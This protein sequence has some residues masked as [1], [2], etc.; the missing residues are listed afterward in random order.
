MTATASSF[1]N[2]LLSKARETAK[3]N[4]SLREFVALPEVAAGFD[5]EFVNLAVDQRER[6]VIRLAIYLAQ[7]ALPVW[8]ESHPSLT[9]PVEAVAQAEKWTESPCSESAEMASSTQPA[10]VHDSLSVW[11]QEPKKAAWAGRT[12]AWVA[13]APKHGWQAVA[14]IMGS[15]EA[16]GTDEALSLAVRFHSAENQT[17]QSGPRD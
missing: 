17:A 9:G 5:D 11:H 6:F 1:A 10:A 16:L 4:I 15:Q 2:L 14:A 12:A 13:D 8:V 3:E 7:E